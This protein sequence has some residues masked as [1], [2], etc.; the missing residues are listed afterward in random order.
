MGASVVGDTVAVRVG[1]CTGGGAPVLTG[2]PLFESWTVLPL[3]EMR[4]QR[5]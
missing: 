2:E 3:C 4:L 1:V 5:A